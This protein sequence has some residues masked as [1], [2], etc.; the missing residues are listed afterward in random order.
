LFPFNLQHFALWP[1]IENQRQED[2]REPNR[3]KGAGAETETEKMAKKMKIVCE[4][5][6]DWK[7]DWLRN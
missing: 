5:E 3:S 7:C 4:N 2:I 1:A 6:T